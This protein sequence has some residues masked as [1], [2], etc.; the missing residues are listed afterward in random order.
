M[1]ALELV[2]HV[3]IPYWKE[4]LFHRGSPFNISSILTTQHIAGGREKEGRP[5]IFF[6]LHNLFGEKF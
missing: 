5:T 6:T 3:A 4:F 2:D 1:I